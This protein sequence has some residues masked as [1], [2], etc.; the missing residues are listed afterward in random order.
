[1]S[2]LRLFFA[3]Q[4]APEQNAA[5][6]ER[7]APLVAHLGSKVVPAAN[8]HATLCFVGA[9]ETERLDALRAAAATLG[10]RPVRLNFDALE[11]W[12]APK[13]LCATESRDS[14]S[15]S[16]LAIALAEAVVAAGFSPDLHPFRPHLTLARKISAAQAATVPW[17]LPLEPSVV[18]RSD[19]FVLMESRR[20][21]A[22]S[23][24]SAV[25]SWS[26]YG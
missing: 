2:T 23:I 5:L 7:V 10:G 20:D 25:D 14:S 15:A 21:D 4:P 24:Y 12:G 19:R 8:L 26:L 3:L 13:I 6:V 9:V 17:P 11:Y 22:G 18:M 16:E 1:M